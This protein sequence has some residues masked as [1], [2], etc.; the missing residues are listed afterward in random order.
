MLLSAAGTAPVSPSA[1]DTAAHH[2]MSPSAAAGAPVNTTD[3]ETSRLLKL[4][5]ELR[6]RIYRAVLVSNNNIRANISGIPEPL[7]LAAS[8]QIRN[9]AITIYY[10]ENTFTIPVHGYSSDVYLVAVQRVQKLRTR[11]N[12]AP[13]V[14]CTAPN[15]NLPNWS[16]VMQWL[17]RYHGG[18]ITDSVAAPE[19]LLELGS[20][21][22]T[23]D[24][25]IGGMFCILDG[26]MEK[27]WEEIQG[28][29]GH[30]RVI[31]TRLDKRWGE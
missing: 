24:L 7:L 5:G 9:E 2:E 12:I 8:K 22:D 31:L 6:N 19:R 26:M 28:L 3:T 29:L 23:A 4:S 18:L 20:D 16:N 14:V 30:Q 17:K 1:A 27:E 11:Y 13:E 25:V 21:R 15:P 10:N